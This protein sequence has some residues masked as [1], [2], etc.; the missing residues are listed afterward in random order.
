METIAVFFCKDFPEVV[1]KAQCNEA[2][3]LE[4]RHSLEHGFI[5]WN[6]EAAAP[7]ISQKSS[8]FI[9]WMA[10]NGYTV[11]AFVR[12]S[13]FFEFVP[14]DDEFEKSAAMAVNKQIFAEAFPEAP[15]N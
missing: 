9:D 5:Y 2:P 8:D 12:L 7:L 1:R 6:G 4:T 15:S 10:T 11:T 14:F 3:F 13:D